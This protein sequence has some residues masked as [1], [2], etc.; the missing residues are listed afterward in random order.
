MESS[1]LALYRGLGAVRNYGIMVLIALGVLNGVALGALNWLE[2]NDLRTELVTLS[3]TLPATSTATSTSSKTERAVTLP[4]EIL[5]FHV[6]NM[7]RTGFYETRIVDKE[8]LA[9]ANP[10]NKYILMKSEDAIRHE[11]LNFAMALL[12]VYAGE[13][14][15][16]LGWWLFVRTKVRELFEVL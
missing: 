11:V 12:A 15:L 16:L 8:Y 5:S 3:Q 14:V 10:D 13:I 9:Y 4:E 1:E 2:T 6:T 7:E